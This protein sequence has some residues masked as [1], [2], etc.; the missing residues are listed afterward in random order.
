[1]LYGVDRLVIWNTIYT[2]CRN[3]FFSYIHE[4]NLAFGI[5]PH[6]GHWTSTRLDYRL[7]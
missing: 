3:W 5:Y 7:D 6:I 4:I 2:T 1:M